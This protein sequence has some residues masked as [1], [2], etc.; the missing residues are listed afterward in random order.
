MNIKYT[1]I[2]SATIPT[3]VLLLYPYLLC[4]IHRFRLLNHTNKRC[5][6]TIK[7]YNPKT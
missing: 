6:I 4:I 5:S 3:E 7:E 1:K 2:E